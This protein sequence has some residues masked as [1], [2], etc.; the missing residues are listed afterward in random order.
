MLINKLIEKYNSEI[1]GTTIRAFSNG[2]WRFSEYP[3][4]TEKEKTYHYCLEHLTAQYNHA[5]DEE[6][7][8]FVDDFG[9]GWVLLYESIFN[10]VEMET[11]FAELVKNKTAVEPY[12]MYQSIEEFEEKTE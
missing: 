1:A 8:V 6:L 7:K 12:G 11:K 3:G 10:L 5:L 9:K 4:E 2:G